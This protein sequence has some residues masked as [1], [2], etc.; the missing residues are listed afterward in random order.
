VSGGER[1]GSDC[2]PSAAALQ[3]KIELAAE[4]LAPNAR[5]PRAIDAAARKGV[6][7]TS[8]MPPASSKKRSKTM[9]FLR[10]AGNPARPGPAGEG[11]RQVCKRGSFVQTHFSSM[12]HSSRRIPCRHESTTGSI[13]SGRKPANRKWKK[14]IAAAPGRLAQ[15]EKELWA[16]GRARSSTRHCAVLDAQNSIGS[17]AQ[18]KD[19]ARQ[20]FQLAKS[21]LSVPTMWPSGSRITL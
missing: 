12:T 9:V 17:I 16:A 21:S 7:I 3:F 2:L 10:S 18:L 1:T 6:W 5:P 4:A 13:F 19:I 15:P 8:C 14:L 11:N 20:G